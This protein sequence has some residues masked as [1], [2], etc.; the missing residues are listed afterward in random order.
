MLLENCDFLEDDNFYDFCFHDEK[1]EF[2]KLV[3]IELCEKLEFLTREG[4]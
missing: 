1:Q 3:E 4:N 2:K